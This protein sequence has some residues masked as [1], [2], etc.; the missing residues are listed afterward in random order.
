[1]A[2]V[3]RVPQRIQV[4][5]QVAFDCLAD[6]AA[7]PGWMPSAFRPVGKSFRRLEEGNTFRVRI[8]GSLL[9]S[10]CHVTVVKDN[11]EITWTGGKKGILWAEHRFLFEARG[12]DGVEVESVESWHGP[13]AALLRRLIEPAAR[14]VGK[15]QL[16]ALQSAAIRIHERQQVK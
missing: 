8:L 4:P 14:K 6:H 11:A 3:A 15:D 5:I 1:M 12:D 16:Q 10:T 9:P 7:W 2:Y 13:L